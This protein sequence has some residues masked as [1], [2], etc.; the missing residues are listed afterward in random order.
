MRGSVKEKAI[1]AGFAMFRATGVHKLAKFARGAGVILMFHHVRPWVERDF[2][3]NRLLEI[4][5]EFLD[6]VL[7]T[8]RT[9]GFDLVTLDEATRR[10]AAGG[11]GPPFA[12]LTFD[13]G[14]RDN[15]EHALPV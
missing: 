5:P 7:E 4:I 15:L 2:A 13:D 12:A 14:Y 9:E 11:E 8:L 1:A 3:P 10:L 6:T